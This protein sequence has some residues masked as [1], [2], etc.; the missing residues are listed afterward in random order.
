MGDMRQI[1]PVVING[2]KVDVVNHSIPSSPLWEKFVIRK[3]TT[4]MRL[5]PMQNI[6]VES[7][8]DMVALHDQRL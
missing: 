7:E 8:Q 6:D 2:D 4:N 1:A 3:L 5:L